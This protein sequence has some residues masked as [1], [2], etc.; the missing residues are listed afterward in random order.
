MSNQ[1]QRSTR[2]SG[3]AA[4][5]H[6]SVAAPVLLRITAVGVMLALWWLAARWIGTDI[7]P[8]PDV[9]GGRL[10]NVVLHEEFVRH[11]TATVARVS[12]ALV[13]SLGIATALG[14]AMGLN[15]GAER[16]FDG[17]VLGGRVMPGLAWALL[18]VMVIGVSGTAPIL[19]VVLAVSPLLTLQ[20]WEG[21]KALDRD[22]FQMAQVFEVG[23]FGRLRHIVV[24][25]IMP[26]IVGGAKLGLALSWKV[27]VLAELFGV[28]S[29]V[30]YE[31]NR[32]F[33]IFSLDGVL[34]WALAFAAVMAL[35][36]YG[37]IAPLYS[38]LTRWRRSDDR[39]SVATRL[40][41]QAAWFRQV[42]DTRAEVPI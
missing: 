16:F 17:I 8:T 14:I 33:Q 9:V 1:Q 6:R 18:A 32:N 31:I 22:L 7:I 42:R 15:R 37:L 20:I 36:E 38:H 25:A 2:G 3:A 28:R 26:S 13:V 27:T 23:R 11:M 39:L 35:I 24:P 30:G 41:R 5:R 34:A 10:V 4:R 29:G 21:T 40:L 19:A 12:I